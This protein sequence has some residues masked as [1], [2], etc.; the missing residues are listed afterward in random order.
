MADIIMAD[1]GIAFDGASL[2]GGPLGGA[3]TAFISMAVALARRGHNVTVKNKCHVAMEKDG[4]SWSPLD[5][6]VP[7]K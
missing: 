3:E 2:E 4:V 1:D 7:Q 5:E 6:G